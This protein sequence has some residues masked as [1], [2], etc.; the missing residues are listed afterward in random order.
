MNVNNK[1][2]RL[3]C[4]GSVAVSKKCNAERHFTTMLKDYISKYPYSSEIRRIK[5]EDLKRNLLSYRA[6]FSELIKKPK[7]L[8]LLLI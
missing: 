6:I 2:V 7:W 4:N 3:I 8:P 1:Y 5:T